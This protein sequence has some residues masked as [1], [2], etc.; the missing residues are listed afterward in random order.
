MPEH[1]RHRF[2]ELT[3][4]DVEIARAHAARGDLYEHLARLGR[5]QVHLQDLDGLTRSPENGCLRLHRGE[6]TAT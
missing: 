3:V 5:I 6:T 4:D 1:E 2:R